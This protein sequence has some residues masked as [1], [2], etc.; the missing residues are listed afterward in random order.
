[1]YREN[2]N[3]FAPGNTAFV[4]FNAMVFAGKAKKKRFAVSRR[5]VAYILALCSVATDEENGIALE[6]QVI[7]SIRMT[8]WKGN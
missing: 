7:H 8:C 4:C 2:S 1:M 6:L 5:R 3:F